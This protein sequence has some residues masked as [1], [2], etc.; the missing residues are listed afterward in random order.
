VKHSKRNSKSGR[1]EPKL[2]T[3]IKRAARS[4]MPAIVAA[5]CPFLAIV[6]VYLAG[7]I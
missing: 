5:A 7:L 1:F 3:R 4:A 6:P 2:S